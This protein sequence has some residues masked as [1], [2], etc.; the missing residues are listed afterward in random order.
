MPDLNAYLTPKSVAVIGASNNDETLRGRI[1]T[2]MLGHDYAGAIYPISQS[3]ESV[4]GLKAYRH[5]GDA[6]GPVDLAVLII[7]AR[8]VP[9]ALRDCGRAGV[10]AAQI[11][12]SGFAEEAGAD[13]ARQQAAIR[14]IARE[15]DMAVCGPNSEGFANTRAKLAPTF[16]PAMHGNEVALIPDYRSDGF[17]TVVAQSGGVGFAFFDHGRPKELPFN[18][19]VTTG[20]EAALEEL[21]FVDH[22]IDRDETDVFLLF[23]EDV[24]TPEK[25]ARVGEKALRAGKP[26]IV[27]KVGRS[28]AGKRAAAS[29]TAALTGSY[30][31]YQAMF[32]RYGYIESQ[33]LE[34][35]VDIAGC[36]SHWGELLPRGKRIGVTTASGGAGGMMADALSLAGLELPVLDAETRA[37]IDA[38]LPSYGTSQNPV[39]ATAQAVRALGYH[40]LNA[41]VGASPEVDAVVSIT[42]AK[43][44]ATAERNR[45]ALA[46]LKRT[47]QKPVFFY[48][49][50]LPARK[51]V[52][53]FGRSGVPLISN[54]RNCA[55]AIGAMADYHTTRERFLTA[56]KVRTDA[57]PPAAALA[58]K[59]RRAGPVLCE[60]EAKALLTAYGLAASTHRLAR[61][62]DAAVDAAR[63]IDGPVAMKIQSPDILHKTDAGGVLLDVLGEA[64]VRAG[65]ERLQAGATAY[66]ADADVHGVL[67]EPMARDGREVILGVSRD[68]AFGPMLM[69]GLGGVHVEVLRDVAFAPAPLR[70]T[71]AERLLGSLKGRPLL[72]G[73][74]GETP[75]DIPA[76]IALMEKLSRFAA[77][78]VE[79]IEEIDLNPVVVHPAGDGVTVADA[80]IVKR[81]S[82]PTQA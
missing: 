8:Y 67:V 74:R 38:H 64:E 71:E 9:D 5:I 53:I 28:D 42:S 31:G 37:S 57:S 60:Y 1:M 18:Y 62:A 17:V 66:K 52:E 14:D 58:D 63:A 44:S 25:L 73:R 11:I 56:P 81:R 61:D 59:L 35:M 69:A 72:D 10:R 2:V 46:E 6:P 30:A 68:A 49:Y 13:G 7:P 26:I 43:N 40:R 39:D 41:M 12:T 76:L 21:D 54:L 4:M 50:T 33:E 77:D 24:K 70:P 3:A 79:E 47:A 55:R 16:S 78:F 51:S 19:V 82:N 65:F 36:F 29:H 80:L 34:E 20:N 27:A 22:L 75:A 48:S 23:M 15:F 45:D 32:E